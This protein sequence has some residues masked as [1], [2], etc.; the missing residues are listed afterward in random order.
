[1]PLPAGGNEPWPPKH[2]DPVYGRSAT[3]AAW[4]SGG[5]E[6]LSAIYGGA[7]NV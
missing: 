3:W 1:M 4:Y 2:L 5:P 7:L 6:Q